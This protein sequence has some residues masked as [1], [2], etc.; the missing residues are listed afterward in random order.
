M[1]AVGETSIT[2]KKT[3]MHTLNTM[4]PTR[5]GRSVNRRE[6]LTWAAASGLSLAAVSALL[7]PNALAADSLDADLQ[8][9]LAAGVAAGLPGVVLRIER[10]GTL[11][12]E[13][14]TGVASIEDQTPLT[15][16]HRFRLGSIAKTFTATVVLQLVDEGVLSLDDTVTQ[17]LDDGAVARI[18]N[19]DQ[20]TI[21]QLLNHTSG[22]YDYADE[23]DSPMWTVY[24]GENPDWE[25]V[26]TL[27]ELLAI[28]D[29]TNHPP[30]FAPGESFHYSNTGYVLAGLIVEKATG[31]RFS[32]ELTSRVL[33]P[34]DL[35][36][37]FLAEGGEIPDGTV[38]CYHLLDDQLV[39]VTTINLSW[40]WA[41]GG[42]VS[43]VDDVARFARAVFSG[44]LISAES[45][46][47][48]FAFTPD[49]NPLLAGFGWGMGVWTT[50]SDA[51]ERLE[52]GG[53]GTGFTASMISFP[54]DDLIVVTLTNC[55]GQEDVLTTAR[56][57]AI[58]LALA[59]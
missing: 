20:I 8:E 42:V 7:A 1:E 55:A 31:N 30:Y 51:G 53:G 11:I 52:A 56:E 24:L 37:T 50:P 32:A 19:V 22:I 36:D 13:G 3:T 43:T 44:E 26:W 59:A 54:E 46:E 29:G 45:Y 38:D 25:K 18:P 33:K 41:A 34:L 10:G 9:V 15:T 57:E 23:S 47:E 35:K 16:A 6:L 4:V 12:Y 21:R 17:W 58:R 40:T 48:M 14:A 28:A 39:N 27:P 5:N 49:P 2:G